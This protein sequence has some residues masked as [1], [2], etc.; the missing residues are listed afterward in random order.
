VVRHQNPRKNRPT[1]ALL[2]VTQ[3]LDELERFLGIGEDRF[4][5][6]KPVV[7][8]VDPALYKAP[9]AA[10]HPSPPGLTAS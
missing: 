8:V 6:R 4:S 5:T 7:Y 2:D 9:K 3:E 10:R 1:V